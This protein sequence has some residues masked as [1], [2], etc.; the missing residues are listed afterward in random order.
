MLQVLFHPLGRKPS[1][2]DAQL[3]F[4]SLA[5]EQRYEQVASRGG[6]GGAVKTKGGRHVETDHSSPL[7]HDLFSPIGREAMV[8][9]L[10]PELLALQ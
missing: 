6:E 5:T 3:S 7:C 4:P 8:R 10:G 9:S 2:R 1:A